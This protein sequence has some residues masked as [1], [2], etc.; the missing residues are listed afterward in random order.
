MG[1][2]QTRP[3]SSTSSAGTSNSTVNGELEWGTG[4]NHGA[5]VVGRFYPYVS[6]TS[7]KSL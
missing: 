3:I 1:M 5:S 6:H 2:R 4:L 7:V